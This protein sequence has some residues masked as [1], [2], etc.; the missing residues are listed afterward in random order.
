MADNTSFA[1]EEKGDSAAITSQSDSDPIAGQSNPA[2]AFSQGDSAAIAAQDETPRQKAQSDS[3]S[4]EPQDNLPPKNISVKY[5]C[6]CRDIYDDTGKK[7]QQACAQHKLKPIRSELLSPPKKPL[8]ESTNLPGE[9][10]DLSV[11]TP[12]A[13]HNQDSPPRQPPVVTPTKGRNFVQELENGPVFLDPFNSERAIE[14]TG[15]PNTLT[16]IPTQEDVPLKQ[17]SSGGVSNPKESTPKVSDP[18]TARNMPDTTQAHEGASGSQT[19][20]QQKF[21]A[22]ELKDL[23]SRLPMDD[24]R[25]VSIFALEPGHQ[26]KLNRVR[27]QRQNRDGLRSARVKG[28]HL[29][30]KTT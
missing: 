24:Q 5:D 4:N 15:P 2:P 22:V 20:Q 6:G 11:Y 9:T 25:T 30:M 8:G 7:R 12:Q 1:T 19:K 21:D 23:G 14:P 16:T 28:L 27:K 29:A 17:K 3:G 10:R 26:L 13:S 18:V